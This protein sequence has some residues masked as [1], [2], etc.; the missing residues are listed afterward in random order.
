MSVSVKFKN[1]WDIIIEKIIELI[2]S[3]Q[4]MKQYKRMKLIES[5]SES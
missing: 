3:I 5:Y 2:D 1:K 4:E